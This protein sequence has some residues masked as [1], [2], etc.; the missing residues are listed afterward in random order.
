[1]FSSFRMACVLQTSATRVRRFR[2]GVAVCYIEFDR[3][4]T[5][6]EARPLAEPEVRNG[7]SALAACCVCGGGL[8]GLAPFVYPVPSPWSLLFGFGVVEV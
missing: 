6:T 3:T 5:A 7:L 4:R 2:E 8:P 1:M